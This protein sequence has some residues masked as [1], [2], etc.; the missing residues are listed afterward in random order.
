MISDITD[1]SFFISHIQLCP[2]SA[3]IA[4][5]IT[6]THFVILNAV[7]NLVIGVIV[8]LLSSDPST[9]LRCAQDDKGEEFSGRVQ[10]GFREG[11]GREGSLG[12]LSLTS[13]CFLS[14][15][16]LTSL[17]L[18]TVFFPMRVGKNLPALRQGAWWRGAGIK[19]NTRIGEGGSAG[20]AA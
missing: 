20:G 14:D 17:C 16:S 1:S 7:K 9:P 5:A 6:H 2:L 18:F 4:A 8:S 11:S 19:N 15:L 3:R 13:F 10:G 12:A